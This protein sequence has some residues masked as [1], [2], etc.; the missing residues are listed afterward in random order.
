[1]ENTT[2][3]LVSAYDY[4][5]YFAITIEADKWYG[6]K[7]YCRYFDKNWMELE[8]AV[9]S[10]GFPEFAYYCCKR[11]LAKYMSISETKSGT[12]NFTVPVL[13][14]KIDEPKY[15]LSL[16]LA[17]LYGDFERKW[18]LL[19]ELVDDYVKTGEAEVVFF[20]EEQDRTSN[21]WQHVEIEDCALRSLHHS[22]YSIFADLDDRIT[23]LGSSTLVDYISQ[24][25]TERTNFALLCFAVRYILRMRKSPEMYE[26][27]QTLLDHL[28]TLVFR[29]TTSP[30]PTGAAAK[31]VA[32]PRRVMAMGIH[33]SYISMPGY[34]TFFV[35]PDKAINMHYREPYG[36][37]WYKR[38]IALVSR[39]GPFKIEGYPNHLID[40]LYRNVKRRLDRVYG[41]NSL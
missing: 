40:P 26:G 33:N 31:C 21:E 17:P 35:P 36:D 10:I 18:L 25:L 15:T 30:S 19:A 20:R 38:R 16:C 41:V 28:P 14:R 23:A 6:K 24:T 29:N 22:R 37:G 9:E 11:T 13:N 32:D 34:K 5:D 4:S 39:Y 27:E 3:R 12:V 7:A 2:L 1:M 8:P